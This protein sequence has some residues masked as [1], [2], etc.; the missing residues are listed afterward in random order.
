MGRLAARTDRPPGAAQQGR[1]IARISRAIWSSLPFAAIARISRVI[2]RSPPF[3]AVRPAATAGRSLQLQDQRPPWSAC[4]GA[5]HRTLST[6]GVVSQFRPPEIAAPLGAVSTDRMHLRRFEESDLDGLADVFSN[7]E[8][9]RFP[10]GRAF[11]R[12]ETSQFLNA[13]LAEWEE[14]GFGCW[15]AVLKSSEAPI[16]YVGLSVP[17]FLPEILPAVEVGWRFDPA[18]WGQGLAAEGARAA[19]KEGFTT[20]GLTEICS[21]PQ[22]VNPRS[23]RVCERIGMTFRHTVDCPPTDRRGGVEARMYTM[24]RDEWSALTTDN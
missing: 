11:T 2:R 22:S 21:L 20:L 16:G 14:C 18:V 1:S 23:F 7:A 12:E 5:L 4:G 15:I 19:L 9:W 8:V 10:Y 24:S 3:A 17:M 6:L 13:Q